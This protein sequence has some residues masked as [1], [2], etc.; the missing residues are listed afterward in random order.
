MFLGQI[1]P[2]HIKLFSFISMRS[3]YFTVSNE[4]FLERKILAKH[5]S[6]FTGRQECETTGFFKK[7]ANYKLNAHKNL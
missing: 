1:K 3:I 5:S 7:E 6:S 2:L 4:M